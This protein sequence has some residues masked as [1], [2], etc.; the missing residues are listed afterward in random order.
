M[1]DQITE[2]SLKTALTERL[3]AVHVEVTDMSGTKPHHNPGS[4]LST[5]MKTVSRSAE[6]ARLDRPTGLPITN[7]LPQAAVASHLPP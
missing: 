4:V 6:H 5:M 1:A 2:D 7:L 3:K